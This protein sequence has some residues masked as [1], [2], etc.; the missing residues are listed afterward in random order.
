LQGVRIRW[1]SVSDAQETGSK[2]CGVWIEGRSGKCG[3]KPL[4]N[5]S[6]TER[7]LAAT[8]SNGIV[9]HVVMH[10]MTNGQTPNGIQEAFPSSPWN[11]MEGVKV[12]ATPNP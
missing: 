5:S 2:V 9:F 7:G 11:G 4:P 12:K 1:A 8:G 10:D 6:T 3:Q